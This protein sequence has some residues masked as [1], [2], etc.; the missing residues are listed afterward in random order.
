MRRSSSTA[1]PSLKLGLLAVVWTAGRAG[2]WAK[3]AETVRRENNGTARPIATDPRSA[4][5][6]VFLRRGINIRL[7]PSR[8]RCDDRRTIALGASRAKTDSSKWLSLQT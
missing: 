3:L 8:E 1:F 5:V 4:R 2:A 7:I 6:K